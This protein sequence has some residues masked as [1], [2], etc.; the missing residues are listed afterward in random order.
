MR[1]IITSLKILTC[2]MIWK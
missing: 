1:K 2:M